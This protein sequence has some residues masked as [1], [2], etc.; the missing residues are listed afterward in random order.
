MKRFDMKNVLIVVF[1]ISLILVVSCGEEEIKIKAPDQEVISKIEIKIG[2]N[3]EPLKLTKV[4]EDDWSFAYREEQVITGEANTNTVKQILRELDK[5]RIN[6]D[7]IA[8]RN[9]ENYFKYGVDED[10]AIYLKIYTTEDEEPDFT[11]IIG[12]SD[13]DKKF[14]FIRIPGREPVYRAYGNYRNV[15]NKRLMDFRDRSI[16]DYNFENIEKIEYMDDDGNMVTLNKKEIPTE[17]AEQNNEEQ[18]EMKEEKEM[19]VQWIRESDGKVYITDKVNSAVEQISRLSASSFIDYP[20]E[21]IINI[22]P[23][24]RV[25]YYE[26]ETMGGEYTLKVLKLIP[27][28]DV[29]SDVNQ[30]TYLVQKGHQTNPLYLVSKSIIDRLMKIRQADLEDKPEE[31]ENA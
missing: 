28:D 9:T 20:S 6:S 11:F 1:V 22:K 27:K 18:T 4:Q 2:M 15:L 29:L 8:S 19:E 25:T 3:G 24:F 13:I 31:D 7:R 5:L 16:F 14:T 26:K 12:K 10:S 30:D 23:I 17:D 21:D